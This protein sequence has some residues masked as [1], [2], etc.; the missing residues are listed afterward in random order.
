M[1]KLFNINR[2]AY[3]LL[4]NITLALIFE[5]CIILP[6]TNA[7]KLSAQDTIED[8]EFAEFEDIEDDSEEFTSQIKP[9]PSPPS[10]NEQQA[11]SKVDENDG[12][13]EDDEDE[14]ETVRDDDDQPQDKMYVHVV[15]RKD[16]NFFINFNSFNLFLEI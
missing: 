9:T 11:N 16:V 2:L 1:G 6:S 15:I 3:F 4:S 8:N 14:F 5:L 7:S 10:Q 12:I 13:V